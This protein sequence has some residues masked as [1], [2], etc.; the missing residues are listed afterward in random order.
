MQRTGVRFQSRSPATAEDLQPIESPGGHATGGQVRRHEVRQPA[1]GKLKARGRQV[2]LSVRVPMVPGLPAHRFG[3]V[4]QGPHQVQV[5][6]HRRDQR[7]FPGELTGDAVGPMPG[8]SEVLDGRQSRDFAAQLPE[9]AVE[10]HHMPQHKV[11][12]VGRHAGRQGL[13]FPKLIGDRLFQQHRC[14]RLQQSPRHRDVIT[15][16][17]G[18]DPGVGGPRSHRLFEVA[19]RRDPGKIGF[20]RRQCLRPAGDQGSQLTLGQMLDCLGV[21]PTKSAQADNPQTHGTLSRHGGGSSRGNRGWG[22]SRQAGERLQARDCCDRGGIRGKSE[23][24][25]SQL[26]ILKSRGFV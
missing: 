12:R 1:P 21:E 24:L 4:Q 10:Q 26:N 25:I 11:P 15:G 16:A 3:R 19:E 14:S 13:R 7:I 2:Q 6:H 8:R 9:F 17:A 22:K 20:H 5:V 23:Y 18:H